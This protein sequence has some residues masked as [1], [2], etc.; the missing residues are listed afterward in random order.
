MAVLIGSVRMFGA[1]RVGQMGEKTAA[2]TGSL[3]QNIV[4]GPAPSAVE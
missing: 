2:V 3:G 1:K 4:A